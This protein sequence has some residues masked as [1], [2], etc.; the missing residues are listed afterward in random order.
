MTGVQTCALPIW[1]VL[2]GIMPPWDADPAAGVFANDASLN[3]AEAARLVAWVDAG[4]K[5]G[6][7]DDLLVTQPPPEP[8]LWPLGQPD[9]IL[10]LDEQS[11]KATGLEAYRYLPIANPLGSDV[12]LRAVTVRPGNRQVVHHA[13]VFS[14][15]TFADLVQVQGGLGGFFAGYVPGMEPVEFPAGTGKLLKKGSYLV[16]QMHYTT[17]GTATTDR[18]ELGLYFAK[19]PPAREQ[20]GRASCRD[21]V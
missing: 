3:P 10:S 12:W 19:T 17:M 14:I 8:P 20:I 15:K 2:T 1:D 9:K 5:R 13:L 6:D 16:F 21:R 7:G 4:A 18:T 11:I